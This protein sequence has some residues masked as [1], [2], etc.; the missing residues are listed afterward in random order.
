MSAYVVTDVEITDANLY[1]Q[2]LEQI[3]ATVEA[4]G[5]KFV[6]RGGEI[7]AILG[8]WTPQAPRHTRIRQSPAGPRLA[9][10]A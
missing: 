4:H 8:N 2:F 1:G 5:G 7:E 6:A 10:L 9:S 3:T